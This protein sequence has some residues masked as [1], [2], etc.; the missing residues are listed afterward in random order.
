MIVHTVGRIIDGYQSYIGKDSI[1][2]EMRNGK[3]NIINFVLHCTHYYINAFK[4]NVVV[5]HLIP[6]NRIIFILLD[7]KGIGVLDASFHIQ[8]NPG[9]DIYILPPVDNGYIVAMHLVNAKTGILEAVRMLSFNKLFSL[10]L[11]KEIQ[12]QL[13]TSHD[14]S[15]YLRNLYEVQ[16]NYSDNDLITHSIAQFNQ[17]VQV[18]Y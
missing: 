17:E 15:T 7:I 8:E 18:E 6:I 13:N 3:P 11:Y 4:T 16:N 10:M 1:L 9:D 14:H 5:G 12:S 2:F